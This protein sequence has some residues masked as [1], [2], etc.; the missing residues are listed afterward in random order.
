MTSGKFMNNCRLHF[1][2]CK[3][4]TQQILQAIAQVCYIKN[5]ILTRNSMTMSHI[6]PTKWV[7]VYV[8]PPI[9]LHFSNQWTGSD[10]IPC[11]LVYKYLPYCTVTQPTWTY[12][13]THHLENLKYHRFR[14]N[15]KLW[16]YT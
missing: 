12:L 13:H 11:S 8:S 6:F 14:W 7:H 16:V 9:M 4:Q 3:Q 2:N 15:S 1:K 10:K 5:I